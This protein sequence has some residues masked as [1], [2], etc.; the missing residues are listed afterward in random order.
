M[1]W[2]S[3]AP[4]ALPGPTE[5]RLAEIWC[6]ALV[7]DRVGPQDDFFRLGGG[8][9]AAAE[10]VVAV[11]KAF[12]PRL[13]L[14]VLQEAPTI[15][16]LSKLIERQT[17]APPWSTLVPLQPLGLRPPFFCVHGAGGTILC[18]A[19]LARRCAP[20]Q[21]F[22]GIRASSGQGY[23]QPSSRVEDVAAR[24]LEAVCALQPRGPYYL[25]GYSFGGSVALEMAQQL[26]ASG[27]RV[28]LLAV[29]DHTP[30]P[31][32]YR[33]LVWSPTLPLDFALNAAQWLVEDV[34]RAGT[35]QRLAALRSRAPVALAQALN[36][37]R[38]PGRGTGGQDV[39]E[40]FAG[41]RL[42]EDFRRLLA[43]HYQAMRDYAPRPYPGRVALFRARVRPLL[44]LHG[45]DL[46]WGQLARGGLEVVTVPGNHETLLKPPHVQHLAATLL[47]H[48][49]RAQAGR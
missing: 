29:L 21:P 47:A 17:D 16:A 35:G 33:R 14:T 3:D 39:D 28:G 12:G 30:P 48:L 20:H 11:E 43:A 24:Y 8:S 5:K 42:P 1:P 38:R 7:V 34:W 25:G 6:R 44:R 4:D 23:E 49:S 32:R 46:G 19:D 31:T 15:E 9:L 22:Y 26:H 40:I 45:R 10:V 13:P 18:L 36:L 41:R 37:L 27:E 2:R